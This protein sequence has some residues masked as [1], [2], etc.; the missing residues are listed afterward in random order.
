[1]TVKKL[2]F[3]CWHCKREVLISV[4]VVRLLASQSRGVSHVYPCSYEDCQKLNKVSISDN[5]DVYEFP[6]GRGKGFL[7]HTPSDPPVLRGEEV[8]EEEDR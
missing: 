5:M 6:L 1:M 2:E 8:H 3:L 7:G 4:P